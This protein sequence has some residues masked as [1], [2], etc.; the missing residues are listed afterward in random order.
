M[1]KCKS[2]AKLF[3]TP[4]CTC[5]PCSRFIPR[6]HNPDFNVEDTYTQVK[7]QPGLHG[8][9][10]IPSG[11]SG[12]NG[13]IPLAQVGSHPEIKVGFT[14]SSLKNLGRIPPGT[15]QNPIWDLR[16]D[17]WDPMHWGSHLGQTWD[18]SS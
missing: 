12:G 17:C 4:A 3:K 6:S 16:W 2:Y 18:P 5:A 7:G 10:S 1:C 15:F 13:G 14:G 8:I 9:P 11:I